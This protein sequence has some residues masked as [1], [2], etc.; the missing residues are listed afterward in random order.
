MAFRNDLERHR[1]VSLLAAPPVKA[2]VEI[3]SFN[4]RLVASDLSARPAS[5]RFPR[6]PAPILR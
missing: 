5:S 3:K 1:P 6:N 4:K 2:W